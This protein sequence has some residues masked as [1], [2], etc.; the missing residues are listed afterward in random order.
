MRKA[1]LSNLSLILIVVVLV[2]TP[3]TLIFIFNSVKE[4]VY[5]AEKNLISNT[6]DTL[7]S[8]IDAQINSLYQ[9][10]NLR[11]FESHKKLINLTNTIADL[12]EEK[13]S[14]EIIEKIALMNDVTLLIYEGEIPFIF[15]RKIIIPS[16]ALRRGLFR[17][18]HYEHLFLCLNDPEHPLL[19]YFKKLLDKDRTIII[20]DSL[21]PL[22][23]YFEKRFHQNLSS[24]RE[25]VINLKIE[26]KGY[27]VVIS[28]DSESFV[29]HPNPKFD[30]KPVPLEPQRNRSLMKLIKDSIDQN[31]GLFNYLWYSDEEGKVVPK[32][33]LVKYYKPLNWYIAGTI[34]EEDLRKRIEILNILAATLVG[35]GSTVALII[36]FILTKKLRENIKNLKLTW[37][38]ANVGIVMCQNNTWEVREINDHLKNTLERRRE[39]ILGKPIINFV[40]QED[41]KHFLEHLKKASNGLFESLQARLLKGEGEIVHAIIRS[42]L[43]KE[44][45]LILLSVTDITKVVELQKELERANEILQKLSSRDHLTGAFN[46]RS[47]E[48]NLKEELEKSK[49]E[50][51]P[52]SIIMLDIDRFKKINDIYGHIIGDF[53]LKSLTKLLT[54]KIRLEDSIYRYGGD[55]FI[56][57]L[58]RTYKAEGIKVAER[59]RSEIENHDFNY[60]VKGETMLKIK[61]TCSFGV[62][63][64]PEDGSTPEELISK[65]DE[66]LYRAKRNGRNRV[67]EA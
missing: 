9:E 23:E 53:V 58:L 55:E 48:I 6:L 44:K 25:K 30:G 38:T 52:L 21:K 60:R 5:S 34:Y 26:E 41:K 40:H 57:L 63:A 65:A 1:M 61:L 36:S 14:K 10:K 29:I 59:L 62:S 51:E 32:I 17:L 22:M 27:V 13:N 46:R 67:E 7:I 56:I 28:G 19:V 24:I 45:N 20:I 66:A 54:L 8:F 16:E 12:I 4:T 42:S 15:G 35:I 50:G 11:F 31:T 2:S 3:V 64:F 47:L 43:I 37:E 33:A 49:E 18:S 39:E